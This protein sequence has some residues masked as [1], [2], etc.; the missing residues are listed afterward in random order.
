VLFRSSSTEERSVKAQ[1]FSTLTSRAPMIHDTSGRSRRPA[2]LA[3][4]ERSSPSLHSFSVAA[5]FVAGGVL[6]GVAGW[7][8]QPLALPIAAVFPA[9]W[10]F[11][12][13]RPVAG[14]VAAGYF[15]GASRGLPTGVSGFFEIGRAS[16]RASGRCM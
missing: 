7:S 10:A 9:L 5:T 4:R 16:G 14:L 2:F 13:S 1:S 6:A 12:P 11:S 15:L 8:G 3:L